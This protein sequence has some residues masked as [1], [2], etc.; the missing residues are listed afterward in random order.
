M[1]TQ[2]YSPATDAE[3]HALRLRCVTST[4]SAA[5]FGHSPYSTAFE[6][7]HRKRAGE[8]DDFEANERME[9]GQCLQAAIAQLAAKRYGWQV[10]SVPEFALDEADHIGASFDYRVSAVQRDGVWV[11]KRAILEVKN[12][13]GL[14]FRNGWQE[15]DFGLEAPVHIETQ[16]QHQL[17]AAD[18]DL[19]YIVALVGGNR[20][21][22][23]ERDRYRDVGRA[24]RERAR[25]FWRTVV[26]G[27]P[28]TPDYSRDLPTIA[29]LYGYAEPG[30]V[31][32][33]A[34]NERI[35]ELCS[36]YTT[37]GAVKRDAE[38]RQ[39]AAKAE[40]LTLIGAAERVLLP[41]FSF[42]AGVVARKGY[43]VDPC[44][45]RNVRIQPKKG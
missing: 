14:A 39:E 35:A 31:L 28:P 30:K 26:D 41:G 43:T 24:I 3:W 8:P 12:V 2:F 22:L 10:D 4:E 42:S 34:G 37:S 29:K 16:L 40:L 45:Y 25:A 15:T 1:S 36:Q 5:L 33:A 9:A 19:G 32:D 13:D 21:V 11:P 18:V 44:T 23:L 17:E 7:W 20:L 27:T 38:E 6:V